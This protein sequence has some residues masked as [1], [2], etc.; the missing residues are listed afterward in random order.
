MTTFCSFST[1]GHCLQITKFKISQIVRTFFC[2]KKLNKKVWVVP[3]PAK[4][5]VSGTTFFSLFPFLILEKFP[6]RLCCHKNE[7]IKKVL[8]ATTTLIQDGL[9][10]YP[11]FL[12]GLPKLLHRTKMGSP[13]SLAS[14]MW[15]LAFLWHFLNKKNSHFF[16]FGP[17]M[18]KINVV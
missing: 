13:F 8:A 11:P 1:S 5:A 2:C 15:K 18:R 6:Q 16:S 4:S 17:E 10:L 9:L 12:N 14:R 7:N 3:A